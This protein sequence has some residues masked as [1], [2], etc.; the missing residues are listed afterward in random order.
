MFPIFDTVRMAVAG[1]AVSLKAFHRSILKLFLTTYFQ[2]HLLTND[3]IRS[4]AEATLK[5][6][7]ELMNGQLLRVLTAHVDSKIIQKSN[8]P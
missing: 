5:E 6:S 8:M 1:L 2:F 3:V 4:T 7:K